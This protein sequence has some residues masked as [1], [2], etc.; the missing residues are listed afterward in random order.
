MHE[1]ATRTGR[2]TAR[3]IVLALLGVVVAL[4]A[5][6]GLTARPRI[7]HWLRSTVITTLE[8]RLD[9]NVELASI[10]VQ[11][12]PVTRIS[13]GPLTIRH[14]SRPD[15]APLIAMD[16]FET[17]MTWRELLRR[18]RRVDTITL[19]GLA[20]AIPPSRADGQPRFPKDEQGGT[21]T[22]TEDGGERNEG[23]TKAEG[24]QTKAKG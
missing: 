16:R 1:P 4:S 12:G 15:V 21:T 2:H 3:N 8:R 22:R 20:I 14:R 17:T 24:R 5:A 13:G 10:S 19:T 9:S 11:I 6:I 18:P 7:E 23:G